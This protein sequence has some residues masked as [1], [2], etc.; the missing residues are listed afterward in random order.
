MNDMWLNCFSF[1]LVTSKQP[2]FQNCMETLPALSCSL[3]DG[4]QTLM[5]V[6]LHLTLFCYLSVNIVD[7]SMSFHGQAR[8]VIGQISIQLT[9]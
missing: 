5:F 6:I 7:M 8:R 1:I 2:V 3:T 9:S 4:K